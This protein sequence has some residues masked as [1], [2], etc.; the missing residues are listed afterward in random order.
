MNEP[1]SLSSKGDSGDDGK[2]INQECGLGHDATDVTKE[3]HL[4]QLQHETASAVV[5][6]A[7][8]IH[9]INL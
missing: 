2:Q 9:N 7:Q 1:G 8:F 3:S 5:Q 4:D 6:V